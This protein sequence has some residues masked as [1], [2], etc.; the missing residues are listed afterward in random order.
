MEVCYLLCVK[1]CT[2]LDRQFYRKCVFPIFLFVPCK[3]YFTFLKEYT[4][5][6]RYHMYVLILDLSFLKYFCIIYHYRFLRNWVNCTKN[7]TCYY[8]YSLGLNGML[9]DL[10][11]FFCVLGY[12]TLYEGSERE[13]VCDRLTPGQMYMVRVACCNVAGRSEVSSPSQS[14]RH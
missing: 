12:E 7:L 6:I 8:R 1:C 3:S 9:C 4:S 14:I 5:C 10:L 13:H 2:I 11:L